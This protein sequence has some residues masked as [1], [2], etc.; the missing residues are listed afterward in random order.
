MQEKK[1]CYLCRKL[2]DVENTQ[3]LHVHH[4]MFGNANRKNS[5]GYGL[6]VHLCITHHTGSNMAV[7]FNRNLDLLLKREAQHAFESKIG[8]REDFI[9]IFGRNYL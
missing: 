4:V 7:H 3:N 2:H 9:K 1:E 5:E 6:T 8:S